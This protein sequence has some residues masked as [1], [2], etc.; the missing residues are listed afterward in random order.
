V[1]ARA[2]RIVNVAARRRR[3]RRATPLALCAALAALAFP[4]AARGSEVRVR[5]DLY[6]DTFA[7]RRVSGANHD[8]D[9]VPTLRARGL[10]RPFESV[11]IELYGYAQ[12]TRELGSSGITSG[13]IHADNRAMLGAGVLLSLWQ[14][15]AGLFFQA[16]PALN[17]VDDGRART[18]LDARGGGFLGVELR[19]CSPAPGSGLQLT[20]C[21]DFYG[22]LLYLARFDDD[23]ASFA[24]ARGGATWLVTGP[25]AWQALVEGRAAAD[26]N[27]DFYDNF[28]DA[29]LAHRWRLL[30]PVRLDV[31]ASGVAGRY[32]GVEN[33]DPA[34]DP[35][36]YVDLRLEAATYFEF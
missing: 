16:G 14:G 21:A 31:V 36:R 3:W 19:G 30:R 12:V 34:P 22:D 13:R 10:V 23:V 6:A 20:P 9:G 28:A 7:W 15:R 1:S 11:P 5:R 29:G 26:R 33:V 35:L 8:A 17:L 24:R 27:H 25:V 32:R 18:L 2:S 4:V